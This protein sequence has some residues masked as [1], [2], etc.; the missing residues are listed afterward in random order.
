MVTCRLLKE[1]A[2]EIAPI[3]TDLFQRSY[4]TGEC[5]DLW[6]EANVVPIYK[7]DAVSD[8]GNYRPVSLTCIPCKLME[9]IVAHH[10]RAH[11]DKHGSLTRL[12]HRFRKKNSC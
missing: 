8:P 5:P 11:L 4:D 9:H 3:F 7:K 10:I 6:S 12:N 1:L 2:T